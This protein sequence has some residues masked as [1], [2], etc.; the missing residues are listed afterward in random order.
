MSW[1]CKKKTGNVIWN[2]FNSE[3]DY[4][5]K[6]FNLNGIPVSPDSPKT[7]IKWVPL[8]LIEP[9]QNRRHFSDDIWNTFPLWIFFCILIQMSLNF[10]SKWQS[11]LVFIVAWHR[12][13]DKRHHF[14]MTSSNGNIFRV[15]GPLC[16][17]FTGPRWIP[18]TKASDAELWCLLWSAPE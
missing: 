13:S 5:L 17:D 1:K 3:T 11:T 10:G 9:R 14:M 2:I 6:Q 18:H 15:T 16:G 7:I 8:Q 12:T 4:C